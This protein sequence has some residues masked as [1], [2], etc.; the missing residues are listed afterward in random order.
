[1][2]AIRRSGAGRIEAT[3]K[4]EVK[5]EAGGS[6]DVKD[7]ALLDLPIDIENA[8]VVIMRD[9]VDAAPDSDANQLVVLASVSSSGELITSD[10]EIVTAEDDEEL[11]EEEEE[12]EEEEEEEEEEPEPVK[13]VLEPNQCKHCD[14]VFRSQTGLKR[15]VMACQP[16][17]EEVDDPLE[18]ELCYCCGEPVDT[19]HK[20]GDHACPECDKLFIDPPA[21][22]RHTCIAHSDGLTCPDCGKVCLTRPLLEKHIACHLEKPYSCER[23]RKSFTRK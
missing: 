13:K 7:A 8:S 15:H 9:G 16:K 12:V 4:S 14:K 19:A 18:F 1:M 6:G 10:G 22:A 23:C 2:S 5:S 21:L 17:E 11:E 20:T 3:V